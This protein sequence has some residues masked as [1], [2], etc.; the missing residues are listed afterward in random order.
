[1][2]TISN[3][4]WEKAKSNFDVVLEQYLELLGTPGVITSFAIKN[5]FL[6]LLKRWNAGERTQELYAELRRMS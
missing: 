4:D 1:M 2:E 3:A 5:V 6:P